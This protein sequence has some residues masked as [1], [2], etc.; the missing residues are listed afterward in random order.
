MLA[1]SAQASLYLHAN[2]RRAKQPAGIA[3][4]GGGRAHI[5]RSCMGCGQRPVVTT[6]S[7]VI[8]PE[9]YSAVDVR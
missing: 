1:S 9:T 2:P 5:T 7:F 4:G 6:L 8:V 3:G